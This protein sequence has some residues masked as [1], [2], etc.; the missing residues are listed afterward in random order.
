[1]V[2]KVFESSFPWEEKYPALVFL[3]LF[4]LSMVGKGLLQLS[5]LAPCFV[6]SSPELYSG[7]Y[8]GEPSYK[9]HLLNPE[10]ET[11]H[12]FVLTYCV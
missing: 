9:F 10:I 3:V 7:D 2:L 1:M 6:E 4:W 11:K 12:L 5:N 8:I